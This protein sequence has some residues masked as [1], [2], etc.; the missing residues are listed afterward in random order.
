MGIANIF[1]N[2][3]MLKPFL[4]LID[5]IKAKKIKQSLPDTSELDNTSMEIINIKN[6]I[7]TVD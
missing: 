2:A 5:L 1:I 6:K 7:N 4:L 3:T